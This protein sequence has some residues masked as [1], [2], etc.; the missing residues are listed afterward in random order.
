[1]S[2]D[3]LPFTVP[4]PDPTRWEREPAKCRRHRWVTFE[5]I[6]RCDRC[7]RYFDPVSAKRGKNNR[8]RGNAI[9]REVGKRL[10]LRR[11]GQ[12]GSSVDLDGEWAVAQVKSGHRYSDTDE[13]D[14]DA[15]APMAHGRT[16]LLIKVKTPGPGH[17]RRSQVVLRLSELMAEHGD[18]LVVVDMPDFVGL[19]GD[20]H[21]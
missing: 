3:D 6:T 13:R 20:G 11:V 14:L 15:M 1:M 21:A 18:A 19:K 7:G 17:A 9:E 2:L 10:G 12:F 8:S 16:R 4:V 5:T